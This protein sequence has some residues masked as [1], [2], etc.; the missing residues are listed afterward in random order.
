[1]TE[2]DF[3]ELDKAVS[4][5]MSNVDTSKRNTA[6]DDPEDKVVTLDT[7]VLAASSDVPSVDGKTNTS[8]QS[9]SAPLAVKRRGQFMDM[10][11]PSSDMKTSPSASPTRRG[12]TIQPTNPN[13]LATTPIVTAHV[14]S[15][16][17]KVS[18][19]EMESTGTTVPQ[20]TREVIDGGHTSRE[21]LIADGDDHEQPDSTD[22]VMSE[23]ASSDEPTAGA[24]KSEDF[25][26]GASTAEPLPSADEPTPLSSPF[27]PDA[28]VE[29]R[30]LGALS[31]ASETQL[32]EPAVSVPVGANQIAQ[33]E[34]TPE[35]DA[36]S[37]PPVPLPDELKSEVVALESSSTGVQASSEGLDAQSGQIAQQYQEQA[38]SG[39]QQSTAIYD[40]STHT[41]PLVASTK[42]S[43]VWKWVLWVVVLV[44]ISILGGAAYFYFTT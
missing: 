6:V 17:T 41:Q 30:P 10:V 29:K 11:H 19:H 43:S 33:T 28:K 31:D 36:Q 26:S 24:T 34:M 35:E 23:V 42:K 12:M 27:L 39:D 16:D 38:S 25:S 4:N 3:E 37:P 13:I 1:M 5:L 32:P 20:A 44:I 2:L 9:A 22:A 40:T 8:S 7:S 18:P 21:S 14:P 15:D